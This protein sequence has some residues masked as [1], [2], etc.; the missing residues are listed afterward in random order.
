M[1]K[2][3]DP[4]EFDY[5]IFKKRLEAKNIPHVYLETDLELETDEQARTRIQAFVEIVNQ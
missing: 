3:C 5:P 4:E 1:T 2:F